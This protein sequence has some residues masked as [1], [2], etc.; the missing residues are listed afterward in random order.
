MRARYV[1]LF[2]SRKACRI[3]KGVA[4]NIA[5]SSIYSGFIALT[6]AVHA[7]AVEAAPDA[8]GFATVSASISIPSGSKAKNA[9]AGIPKNS[10]FLNLPEYRQMHRDA[11]PVSTSIAV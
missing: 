8:S 6:K 4:M 1:N 9:I 10:H 2:L 7:S 3:A 11:I 5:T